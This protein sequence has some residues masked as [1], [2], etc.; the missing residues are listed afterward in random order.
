MRL[1]ELEGHWE[2]PHDQYQWHEPT[3][4][5]AVIDRR[6]GQACGVAARTVA[7]GLPPRRAESPPCQPR[8]RGDLSQR[9]AAA[10]PEKSMSPPSARGTHGLQGRPAP[11]G[12]H[13]GRA[14]LPGGFRFKLNFRLKSD[15]GGSESEGP[16]SLPRRCPLRSLRLRPRR[17]DASDHPGGRGSLRPG[18]TLLRLGV[19]QNPRPRLLIVTRQLRNL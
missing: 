15:G 10:A 9:L 2:S 11:P 14:C 4:V 1:V 18:T 6:S 8:P 19:G 12:E 5:T 7:R 13:G 16:G 3:T 17:V